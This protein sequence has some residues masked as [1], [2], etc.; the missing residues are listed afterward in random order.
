MTMYVKRSCARCGTTLEG[1][2]NS[3]RAFGSPITEC[4]SCHAHIRLRHQNEWELMGFWERARHII[5][6]TWTAFIWTFGAG[7]L[8]PLLAAIL[9]IIT[10]GDGQQSVGGIL[11]RFFPLVAP[12]LALVGFLLF[13]RATRRAFNHSRER[14]RDPQYAKYLARHGFVRRRS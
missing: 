4:P 10:L 9:Y 12:P 1:W 3:Y 8:I 13:V 6:L 14:L 11:E 2:T 5:S 7:F